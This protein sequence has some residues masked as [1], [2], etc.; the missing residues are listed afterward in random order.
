MP[1]FLV[2]R[3][4]IQQLSLPN[5]MFLVIIYASFSNKNYKYGDI[6]SLVFRL[7]IFT[8]EQ[9]RIRGYLPEEIEKLLSIPES[10]V[11]LDVIK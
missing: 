5:R 8:L 6:F 9:V 10:Y 4:L 3:C 2:Y 7:A 11:E 1:K